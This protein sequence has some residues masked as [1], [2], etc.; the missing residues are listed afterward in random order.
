MH[1]GQKSKRSKTWWSI[2]CLITSAR[3]ELR[4]NTDFGTFSSIMFTGF[5]DNGIVF[6][7]SYQAIQKQIQSW[8][9]KL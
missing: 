3:Q 4:S 8:A 1:Q 7:V 9:G 5:C 6:H 2:S